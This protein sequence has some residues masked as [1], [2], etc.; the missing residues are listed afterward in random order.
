MGGIHDC[1]AYCRMDAVMDATNAWGADYM[2]IKGKARV[3][4]SARLS[5]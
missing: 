4:V 5:E 3:G 2:Q 1:R